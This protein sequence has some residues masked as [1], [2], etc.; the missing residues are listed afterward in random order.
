[1]TKFKVGDKV[2]VNIK[3]CHNGIRTVDENII[4]EVVYIDKF[5]S[6]KILQVKVHNENL[7]GASGSGDINLEK[8]EGGWWYE[9]DAILVEETPFPLY[10]EE[11]A[12]RLLTERG[13]KIENPHEPLKG[14]VVIYRANKSGMIYNCSAELWNSRNNGEYYTAIAIVDWVEG[15]GV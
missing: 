10:S 15:Q 2:K 9:E 4:G 1:M 3:D 12:V 5:Y 6:K 11:A 7:Y 8:Y 14:K 13:Y